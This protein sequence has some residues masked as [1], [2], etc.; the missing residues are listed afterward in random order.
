MARHALLEDQG[1]GHVTNE[2]GAGV[3]VRA[4]ADV[5]CWE[6]DPRTSASTG[7]RLGTA[8]RSPPETGA[9]CN[10]PAYLL[11]VAK[12]WLG[13]DHPST[14]AVKERPCRKVDRTDRGPSGG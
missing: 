6:R 4:S 1:C 13:D 8:R 3:T 5:V 2:I 11:G 10:S 12:R 14:P 7:G 9:T